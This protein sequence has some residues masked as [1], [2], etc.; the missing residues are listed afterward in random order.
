MST[1]VPPRAA[2]IAGA[3]SPS[4]IR[5]TLAPASRSSA[6]RASWRSR[7]R[8]TTSTSRGRI[9]LAPATALTLSVGDALMSIAFGCP[10]AHSRVPSSGSTAT[11]TSGPW[12]LPTSSPL[13]SIGASSFSPSPM[14]T[15][16]S[17]E[18]VS[19][20]A[21]IPSTA[22]WSALSFSPRPTQRPAPIAAFSVTRTSSSARLRS[23]AFG[24]GIPA[25]SD[26]CSAT[27]LTVVILSHSFRRLYSD[28]VEA[29]G[30][31]R[32]RGPAEAEAEGLRVAVEHA[33]LG[34]EAVEV[35]G[36]PDRVVRDRMR[37]AALRRLRRDAWEFGQAL[38]QVLLL[39]RELPGGP[40][41]DLGVSGVAKDPGDPCMRVLDVVDGVLRSL[42]GGELDVDVDRL[43][44][45]AG[46][47]VPARGVDTDLVDQLVERDDVAAPLRDPRELASPDQVDELV[48]E[49]LH[50]LGVVPEHPRDRRV[51]LAR[52]V[53]V[54]SEH[55][56]RAVVATVELFREVDDVGRAIGGPPALLR[57]ADDDPVVVVGVGRRPRPH[58]PVLLIGVEPWQEL[59]QSLLE[60]A[61]KRP[62][63]EVD[64]EALEGRLDL[65]QHRGDRIALL[66]GQVLDVVPVVALLRRLLPAPARLH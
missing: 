45:P 15:T 48:Q 55:V 56:D 23:G 29:P 10:S 53:V 61:L 30:D 7:S 26:A 3:T 1:P 11:S 17:I 22:A 4:R 44:G 52:S 14:T 40:G 36:D 47:E 9:P 6:I 27:R 2:A 5:C 46:D 19:R 12:P 28:Q 25:S 32:L 64:P 65:L 13:K 54:G 37:A 63:V 34:V 24:G 49:H 58:G 51:P 35:V 43:V 57:G 31:D 33:V 8:T 59:P 39:V 42:L 18:T 60:L 38:D 50:A 62:R 20:I 16:P 41:A 21:R 66:G